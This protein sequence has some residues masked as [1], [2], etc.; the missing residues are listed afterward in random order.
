M[1][2]IV[3]SERNTSLPPHHFSEP[4]A[5]TRLK[6]AVDFKT[7]SWLEADIDLPSASLSQVQFITRRHRKGRRAE[8]LTIT[9]AQSCDACLL[10]LFM[11]CERGQFQW[12]VLHA[13]Q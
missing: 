7:A 6:Q 12:I 9:Y 5:I 13:P 8:I 2:L 11:S 10:L 1:I 3:N 4:L